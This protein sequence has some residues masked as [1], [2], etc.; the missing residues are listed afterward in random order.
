MAAQAERR[1]RTRDALLDAAAR[2]LSRYGYADL[3]LERVASE[4]GYTRGALYHPSPARRTS[5]WRSS[6]G[7]TRRGGTRAAAQGD[8][9]GALIAL[10]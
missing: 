9:V 8:P 10:A 6:S 5:R 4:A 3:A 2:G 1:A 7:S